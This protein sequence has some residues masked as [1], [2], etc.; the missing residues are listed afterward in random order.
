MLFVPYV[1]LWPST[2]GDQRLGLT[3]YLAVLAIS[4]AVSVWLL[5]FSPIWRLG[6]RQGTPVRNWRRSAIAQ[7]GADDLN[8]A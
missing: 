2:V 6:R 4:G 5:F 7:A 8:I 1:R 3:I